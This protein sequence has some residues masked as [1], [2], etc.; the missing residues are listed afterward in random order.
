[1]RHSFLCISISVILLSIG[2]ALGLQS[3]ISNAIH[4][5]IGIILHECLVAVALGLNAIR[6]QQQNINLWMHVKFAFLFSLT[7]P[8]GNI[9]GILLGYTPG[10]FGR[11]IS[12]IF[13]GFAA[14]TFI[15]VT[16]LELIPEELLSPNCDT[17]EDELTRLI[18]DNRTDDN[19][20]L[21]ANTSTATETDATIEAEVQEHSHRT[22]S[23]HSHQHGN[24]KLRKIMLLLLGFIIMTL[25]PFLFDQ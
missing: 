19:A 16:F 5:F 18:N 2:L 13:Q 24:T 7:I 21:G 20:T 3:D 25:V 12:A 1:M 6:L 11:F 10:H 15:H 8:V 9:F 17:K 4:L 23:S 22:E 14:G